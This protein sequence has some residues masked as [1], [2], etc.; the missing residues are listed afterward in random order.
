[1]CVS[2]FVCILVLLYCCPTSKSSLL[3][4]DVW[5]IR[6]K[7]ASTHKKSRLKLVDN[8]QWSFAWYGYCPMKDQFQMHS[9]Y[10]GTFLQ[11]ELLSLSCCRD[12][13]RVVEKVVVQFVQLSFVNALDRT[14]IQCFQISSQRSLLHSFSL[15]K[16]LGMIKSNSQLLKL[17]VFHFL[18]NSS[19]WWSYFWWG[20]SNDVITS[21][22]LILQMHFTS[23]A[24]S[25]LFVDS[26]VLF[27]SSRTL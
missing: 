2:V 7:I 14:S 4:I 9:L 17:Q 25:F 5:K 15:L 23:D 24:S 21:G 3:Y 22:A 10:E 8:H 13:N 26:F 20:A 19:F 16:C 6:W 18:M 12:T 1:M 27:C 11:A